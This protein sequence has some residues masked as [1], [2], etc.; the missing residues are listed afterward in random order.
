MNNTFFDYPT[1]QMRKSEMVKIGV[2]ESLLEEPQGAGSRI[3]DAKSAIPVY[4]VFNPRTGEHFYT[5][6]EYERNILVQRG[7]NGEGIGWYNDMLRPSQKSNLIDDAPKK[8]IAA[9]KKVSRKRSR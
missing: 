2:P 6:S 5:E 7:W 4:R 8:N 3:S 1:R 9:E